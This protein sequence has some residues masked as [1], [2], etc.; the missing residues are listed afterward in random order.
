MVPVAHRS[1]ARQVARKVSASAIFLVVC[2]LGAALPASP[3]AYPF[4]HYSVADGLSQSVVRDLHEDSRG[5]LWVATSGGL[6]RWDG[7]AFQVY[8]EEDGLPDKVVEA[9]AE[10]AA[11]HLWIATR[12]GLA[13]WDGRDVRNLT[14]ASGLSVDY[15][16]NLLFDSAGNLWAGTYGG[17]L[18]KLADSAF[19]RYT[20]DHG[21]DRLEFDARGEIREIRH[22]GKAEGFV[23]VETNQNAV[24]EDSRGHLWFG[25]RGL[26]RFDPS[27]ESGDFEPPRIHLTGLRL[28]YEDVDWRQ[29]GEATNPFFGLP[30]NPSLAH[31]QNHVEFGFVG[32]DLRAPDSVLYQ[33]RLVGFDDVWTPPSHQRRVAYPRL[34]PGAYRFEVRV[35]TARSDWSPRPAALSFEVR[36][37]F[38]R[39]PWFLFLAVAV[40]GLGI[41]AVVRSRMAF[42]RRQRRQLEEE[43]EL[44]TRELS[45]ANRAKSE[46]LANM[47]H[48]LE[49]TVDEEVP[50]RIVGD[51]GRLRQI[52]LNPRDERRPRSVSRGGH[53]R[54]S[55]QTRDP[56]A[57]DRGA[58]TLAR[59]GGRPWCPG[60]LT[61]PRPW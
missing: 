14:R 24:V 45:E 58:R 23:G 43:V 53:G 5:Y 20:T 32:I 47:S 46:F 54:L 2:L 10:D 51:A 59:R 11:G 1:R 56:R 27:E 44:R 15:V 55:Q 36:P 25:T 18:D 34:P 33:H 49:A 7:V 35:R 22:F 31:E 19:V 16:N 12:G 61:G 38:W 3:Q 30:R 40:L 21:L 17:G 29:R 48:E 42:L 39:T 8:T 41:L 57:I 13:R 60:G 52:L 6:S 9:L 50:A 26:A 28:S 37:S 4:V